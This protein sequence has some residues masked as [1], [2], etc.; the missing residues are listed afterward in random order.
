MCPWAWLRTPRRPWPLG[1]QTER[2]PPPTWTME[3]S[4]KDLR[5]TAALR[6]ERLV[7]P[8]PCWVQ[9]FSFNHLKL[10]GLAWVSTVLLKVIWSRSTD[11]S[12]LEAFIYLCLIFTFRL[13]MSPL[14]LFGRER[15]QLIRRRRLFPEALHLPTWRCRHIGRWHR[16]TRL[17]AGVRLPGEPAL[18]Q[19]LPTVQGPTLSMLQLLLLRPLPIVLIHPEAQPVHAVWSGAQARPGVPA[20][21]HHVASGVQPAGGGVGESAE[22]LLV[23]ASRRRGVEQ[24]AE[25]PHHLQPAGGRSEHVLPPVD[26]HQAAPRRLRSSTCAT[27]STAAAQRTTTGNCPPLWVHRQLYFNRGEPVRGHINIFTKSQRRGWL[28]TSMG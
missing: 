17:Q 15:R 7:S 11:V 26:R 19:L 16:N 9:T 23:V 6:P 10:L 3:M 12:Y 21:G 28:E 24:P 18:L 25:A 8:R 2:R 20:D 13:L 5:A 1:N 4:W 22:L 27:S 14:R